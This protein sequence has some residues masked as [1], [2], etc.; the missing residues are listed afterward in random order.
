MGKRSQ[1]LF[2]TTSLLLTSLVGGI[3]VLLQPTDAMACSVSAQSPIAKT[4]TTFSF[5]NG[6][7]LGSHEADLIK[8]LGNPQSRKKMAVRCPS[9]RVNLQ[10][11]RDTLV[12]LDSLNQRPATSNLRW[13]PAVSSIRRQFSD[14]LASDDPIVQNRTF[15]R[16]AQSK[17]SA[18]SQTSTA[19]LVIVR[20][21][22]QNPQWALSHDIRVGDQLTKVLKAYG[23]PQ[24]KTVRKHRKILSYQQGNESLRLR[25]TNDRVDTVELKLR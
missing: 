4:N 23:Q 20:F 7:H 15:A 3:T 22:T 11:D 25:F 19:D 1:R 13:R 17:R 16:N 24:F 2:I 14:R 8:R 9:H 10:Y 21:V 18:V 6:L 12:V 5:K